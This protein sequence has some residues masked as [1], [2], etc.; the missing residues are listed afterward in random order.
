M[1]PGHSHVVDAVNIHFF[2]AMRWTSSTSSPCIAYKTDL[3][4]KGPRAQLQ[5]QFAGHQRSFAGSMPRLSSTLR[6]ISG[7]HSWIGTL[8]D[9]GCGLPEGHFS[10]GVAGLATSRPRAPSFAP[11]HASPLK[12]QF[13][14]GTQLARR[15]GLLMHASVRLHCNSLA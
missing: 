15:Q 1:F 14:R 11:G 13:D 7:R 4:L 5:V 10:R 8:W 9:T 3:Q 12:S 6:S 2:V